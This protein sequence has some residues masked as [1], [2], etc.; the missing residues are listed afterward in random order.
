MTEK[1]QLAAIFWSNVEKVKAEKGLTWEEIGRPF[2][3][4]GKRLTSA[5]SSQKAPI[6]HLARNIASSLGVSIDY[7]CTDWTAVKPPYDK[8]RSDEAEV[9]RNSIRT[10]VNRI[11]AI[12]A[13]AVIR[14]VVQVLENPEDKARE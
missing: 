11:S 7:L 2:G 1:E 3:Y 6:I 10:S 4:S 5:R 12:N 13:L 14:D 8:L 9:L